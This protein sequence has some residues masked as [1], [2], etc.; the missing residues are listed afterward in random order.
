MKRDYY[1]ILGVKRDTSEKGIKKAYRQLAHKY[2]PD[3]NPNNQEAET[4]FKEAGEAYAVLNDPQQ[5][6]QYDQFGH[7]PPGTV[8]AGPGFDDIFQHFDDIF[9]GFSDFF[10]NA[11][12][13]S[14][15]RKGANHN[16][17]V[18]LDF[19]EAV[20]GCDKVVSVSHATPCALCLGS[21]C[22]AGTLPATCSTCGGAGQVI[23]KQL[24]I[25]LK[26]TCPTCHG[27]GKVIAEHCDVCRGVGTC[28]IE[29]QVTV[30]IPA[31]VDSGN[32]LSVPGGGFVS[33]S[34]GPPGDLILHL[35]V[36]PSSKFRREGYD[37]HSSLV[38]PVT[39]A[40][41]G[42]TCEVHT[43]YGKEVIDIS[44]GVQSESVMLLEKKGIPKL[45][46]LGSGDHYVHLK[47]SIPKN[48]TGKQKKLVEN[49]EKLLK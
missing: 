29:D 23:Q 4:K 25:T 17:E 2:H 48:L 38:I 19:E 44:P 24:F 35:K 7:S 13:R 11:R 32:N 49:L 28:Q 16:L 22:K 3:K 27:K 10:G 46:S 45:N 30:R 41:L 20:F 43:L 6:S 33:N 14:A 9:G 36:T 42:G 47:V 34:N 31:G 15:P 8:G 26:T 37:V 5:R 12:R 21:G 18:V 39:T 40:M 1:E